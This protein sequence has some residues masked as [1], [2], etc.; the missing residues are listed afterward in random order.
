MISDKPLQKGPIWGPRKDASLLL[1]PPLPPSQ[2]EI[3]LTTIVAKEERRSTPCILFHLP[4][5][6]PSELRPQGQ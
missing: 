1:P 4:R 3:G 6:C 5:A 2:K